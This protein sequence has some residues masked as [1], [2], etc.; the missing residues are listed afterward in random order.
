LIGG[1]G[2]WPGGGTVARCRGVGGGRLG[3]GTGARLRGGVVPGWEVALV[4]S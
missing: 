3:G 4:P 2:S 1:V